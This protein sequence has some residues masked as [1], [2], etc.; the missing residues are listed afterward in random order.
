MLSVPWTPY[1]PP[2]SNYPSRWNQLSFTIQQDGIYSIGASNPGEV[3]GSFSYL[4]V[5]VFRISPVPESSAYGVLAA[6]LMLATIMWH[7][8]KDSAAAAN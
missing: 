1:F 2:G 7:R 6:L 3:Q 8:R 5:D 4:G